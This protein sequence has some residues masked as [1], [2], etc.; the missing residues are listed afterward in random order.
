MASCQGRRAPILIPSY[1]NEPP[2]KHENRPGRSES[3][4]RKTGQPQLA[5]PSPAQVTRRRWAE[6]GAGSKRWQRADPSARYPAG[7]HGSC[8]EKSSQAQRCWQARRANRAFL[9]RYY[10][11]ALAVEMEGHGFLYSANETSCP[12]LLVR[13]IS[14][15]VDDKSKRDAEGWQPVAAARAAAFAVHVLSKFDPKLL[16]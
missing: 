13:G 10:S 4:N 8:L 3:S 12:A 16:E 5:N 15:N 7:R 9:S 14:D 11:D 1:A 6:C 2:Q